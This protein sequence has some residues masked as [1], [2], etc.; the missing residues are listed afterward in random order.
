MSMAKTTFADVIEG[1]R[2][3]I[4]AHAQAQDDG[5]TDDLVALYC[6]DGAVEVPDMGTFE[7]TEVLRDTFAGWAPQLPQ[8]HIVV[9]TLVTDWSDNRATAT[10]DVVFVQKGESGWAVQVV[11]RY[12]DVF[13]QT[14]GAWRLRRR[15]MKFEM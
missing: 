6:P 7:G 1:I 2:A 10:S 9:N 15:T 3:T 11:G 4:A 12:H 8:R 13:Q 14:D 5:R